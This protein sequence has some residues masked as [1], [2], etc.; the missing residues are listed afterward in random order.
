MS[1]DKKRKIIE[2]YLKTATPEERRELNRLLK[3]RNVNENS[4]VRQGL[5]IDI[6]KSAKIMAGEINKQFGLTEKSIK[7]MAKHIVAE[8]VLQYKPDIEDSELTAIVNHM[9]Q[10]NNKPKK[11]PKELLKTMIIQFISYG[12]GNMAE[13]EKMQLPNGWIEKYWGYF[14]GDIKYLITEY[15]KNRIDAHKFWLGIE[16]LIN[17]YS[18]S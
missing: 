4:L 7:K 14:P 6:K 1:D 10:G 2:E 15:L 3:S 8:M 9:V 11:I 16:N 5:N 17:D 13:E 12:S 18:I